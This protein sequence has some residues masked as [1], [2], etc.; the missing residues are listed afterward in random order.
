MQRTPRRLPMSIALA[1]V[2]VAAGCSQLG[3]PRTGGAP[4]PTPAGA[5]TTAQ[6]PTT[7]SS[8]GSTTQ[9][10]TQT[11]PS[12]PTWRFPLQVSADHR[13][14]VDQ[15]G[16]PF[17][18]QGDAGWEASVDLT[19]DGWRSY[20]DDRRARGFNTVLVQMTNPVKYNASSARAGCR[21]RRRGAALPYEH[22][23][24]RLGRRSDVRRATTARTTPPRATSTP[25]FVAEP[26]LLRL[27]R[28]APERSQRDGTCWS[29]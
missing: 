1:V 22:R 10:T 11:P 6:A 8:S 5:A 29:S 24:R 21:R 20:L 14:L 12:A 2:L 23:R 4:A 16:K 17:R 7:Q 13:Y 19:L 28:P 9:P 15:D 25:L 26:R 3:A 27:D 18:V